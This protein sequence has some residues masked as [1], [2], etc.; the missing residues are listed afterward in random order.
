MEGGVIDGT[1]ITLCAKKYQGVCKFHIDLEENQLLIGL[2]EGEFENEPADENASYSTLFDFQNYG[3]KYHHGGGLKADLK[4][5]YKG[6]DTNAIRF[7]VKLASMEFLYRGVAV[8]S[9][10]N[11]AFCSGKYKDVCRMIVHKPEGASKPKME[12]FLRARE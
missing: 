7:K 12:I 6:E 3:L 10:T 9:I 5:I 11:P 2:T 4:M 1:E 8:G